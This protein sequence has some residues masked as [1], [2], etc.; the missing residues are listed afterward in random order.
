MARSDEMHQKS[1]R[2]DAKFITIKKTVIDN[3]GEPYENCIDN[4]QDLSAPFA[5][6]IAEMGSDYHQNFCYRICMLRYLEVACNCS[7]PYQFGLPG[8]RD[9]YSSSVY[10]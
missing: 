2:G 1:N 4:T 5:R 8:S 7:L 10:R 9:T 6:E 3:L